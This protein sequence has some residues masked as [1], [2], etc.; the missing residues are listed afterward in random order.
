MLSER[1]LKAKIVESGLNIDL[2]SKQI[3]IDRATF[4][5][6]MAKNSFSINEVDAIAV[7]LSLTPAEA[8]NIFFAQKGA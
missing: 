5:R 8:T 3:G 2:L 6:K 4:Y 7:A 1:K